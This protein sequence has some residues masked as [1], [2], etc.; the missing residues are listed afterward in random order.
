MTN[1]IGRLLNVGIAKEA[2][3]GTGES[4]ATY[5][6][7]IKQFSHEDKRE[8]VFND[9]ALGSIAE[10][11]GNEIVSQ[12]AEGGF[13]ALIGSQSFGL[14]LLS[15]LGSV[16]TA[17]ASGETIVFDHTF[18]LD[19]SAQH[20]SMTLF[21]DGPNKDL[22]F[23]LAVVNSLSIAFEKGKLLDASVEFMS[24]KGDTDSLTASYAAENIFR[25]QDFSFKLAS[26][27][28]GLD[29]ASAIGI[30]SFNITFEKNTEI[31]QEL[32][33]LDPAD[34]LNK[35]FNISGD[36][37]LLYDASTYEDLALAGTNQAIRVAIVNTDVALGVVTTNP[38]LT[39]DLEPCALTEVTFDRGLN[40]LVKHTISF[41]GNYNTSTSKIIDNFVLTNLATSY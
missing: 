30:E 5:W 35:Q 15:M 25:P 16:S 11:S 1:H 21:L 12:H 24:K 36:F 9:C 27:V 29:G 26:A 7:P 10:V 40:D 38:G 23:P 33:S 22:Q 37:T 8:Y 13:D 41:R 34:I 2:T 4:A 14:L 17:A 39:F 6:L 32:G 20:D 31:Y 3:R 18:T 19:E 28:S